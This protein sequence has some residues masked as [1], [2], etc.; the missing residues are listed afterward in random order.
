MVGRKRKTEKKMKIVRL[1][2]EEKPTERLTNKL[3]II[4]PETK[5]EKLEK[6]YVTSAR[7]GGFK[8][9]LPTRRIQAGQGEI[10]EVTPE[11]WKLLRGKFGVVKLYWSK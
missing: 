4:T 7:R 10:I 3:D 2:K 6:I 9:R 5:I 11:E 8:A 1:K